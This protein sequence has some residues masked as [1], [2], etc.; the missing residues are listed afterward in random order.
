MKTTRPLSFGK[1]GRV[2]ALLTA[3]VLV[4]CSVTALAADVPYTRLLKS[5]SPKVHTV[6]PPGDYV[7]LEAV[8]HFRAD[9]TA[10]IGSET[11]E[12]ERMEEA[13]GDYYNFWGVYIVPKTAA[14]GQSLGG[15]TFTAEMGRLTESRTAPGITV[16]ALEASIPDAP[17]DGG[18]SDGSTVKPQSGDMIIV[19][20]DYAD[21]YVPVENDRGE[22]YCAP[23]YY[24]LPDGTIDYVSEDSEGSVNCQLASGRKVKYADIETYDGR[25][26]GDNEISKVA[27]SSSGGF[28]TVKITGDWS[29]PFNVEAKPYT[30]KDSTNTVSEFDPDKVVITFDY[31]T[32]IKTGS[33]RFPSSSCFKKAEVSTRVRNG[34]EQGVLE[35]TLRKPGKYYGCYAEY[36]DMGKLV[37][38]FLNPVDDLDGA[39]IVIDPGHGSMKTASTQDIGASANGVEEHILN[40]EKAEALA[41]ELESRGAEVYVLDTWKSEELYSLY[42]RMDEAIEWEPHLLVSVHHNT[43]SASTVARGIEVFYNT[44]FSVHLAEEV[45]NSIFEAYQEMDYGDTAVNRGHK[46]SEFA[47]NREKQF[48]SILIEYGFITTA[49]EAEVLSDKENIPIF[50]AYTAD[51]I[52][53][54]LSR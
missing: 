14:P 19:T 47:V 38:R 40:M 35:L 21:V 2:L 45:A 13:D 42:A 49:I 18:G 51:G 23:Y 44:P 34:I 9:V 37:L 5:F 30:Y 27:V 20:A 25:D 1:L 29:V 17:S 33:I 24:Q 7:V 53:A 10:K 46:F 48:A 31:T 16:G 43:S 8:A 4:F 15:I 52:E 6:V 36:T 41:E 26:P 32:E 11:I 54:Y 22:E 12:L 50:A 39:R 3:F 28:T